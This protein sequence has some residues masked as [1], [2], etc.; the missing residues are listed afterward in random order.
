MV[1]SRL[2]KNLGISLKELLPSALEVD[3]W[4]HAENFVCRRRGGGNL[5][6]NAANGVGKFRKKKQKKNDR[7]EGT[8]TSIAKLI[9]SMQP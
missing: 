9:N 2:G 3:E 4:E 1:S 8:R 5:S 7:I 6:E